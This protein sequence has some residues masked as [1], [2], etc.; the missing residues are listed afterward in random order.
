MHLIKL[1]TTE[2]VSNCVRNTH[3]SRFTRS[4]WHSHGGHMLLFRI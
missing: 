2:L 4:Q 1:L 3:S